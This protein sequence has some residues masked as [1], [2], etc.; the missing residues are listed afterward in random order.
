MSC[1]FVSGGYDDPWRQHKRSS[2]RIQ[3]APVIDGTDPGPAVD[4]TVAVIGICGV[5]HIG[6]CL[7]AL[8]VQA[9]APAF[10]VVVVFDPRLEGVYA[11]EERFPDVRFV[12]NLEQRTPL[13]LAARAVRESTGDVVVL[14]EDHCVPERGW[15]ACLVDALKPGRAAAG[16]AVEIAADADSLDWAFWFVDFFRY[17]PPIPEGPG[18]SL[19]VCN[20]AYRRRDLD[21]IASVWETTFHETAVHREM[22]DRFGSLWRAPGARV[23]M[24]RH[25]RFADALRERYA[26]GRLY[27][28]T[29]STFIGRA[30][31]LT[32]AVLAPLLPVLLIGRMK[33]RALTTPG[34]RLPFVRALPALTGLVIAWSWGEWLGYVTRTEPASTAVAPEVET[35]R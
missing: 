10:D 8:A 1:P 24:R 16:G 34:L 11:L 32:Y 4:V 9:G 21:A 22:A 31:W 12:S 3:L 30:R 7:D 19:T 29:R 35:G 25:V 15:L 6:R 17:A 14:T 23:T 33:L 28:A 5:A 26:F 27:G 18:A 13:D 2:P 20:V